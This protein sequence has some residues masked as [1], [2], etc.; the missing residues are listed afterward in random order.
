MQFNY[1]TIITSLVL[2]AVSTTAAFALDDHDTAAALKAAR[3]NENPVALKTLL[4]DA[5]QNS[6]EADLSSAFLLSRVTEVSTAADALQHWVDSNPDAPEDDRAFAYNQLGERYMGATRYAEAAAAFRMAQSFDLYANDQDLEDQIVLA[7]IAASVPPISREGAMGASIT[8]VNDLARLRRGPINISGVTSPMIIDTGAEISVAAQSV[9]EK[10]NMTFLDGDVTV[11]TATDNV[12]GRLAVSN[13]VN[14]GGMVFRNV[15]FLVLPDEQLTFADGQYFVDGIIGLP[16]FAEA[17][18][19]E[20]RD[21]AAELYLGN[22]VPETGPDSVPFYW[23]DSGMGL[24]IS[25]EQFTRPAFFDSGASRSSGEPLFRDLLTPADKASLIEENSTVTGVGG[26][27]EVKNYVLP[28]AKIMVG[29]KPFI[30]SNFKIAGEDRGNPT[31]DMA[32][33]GMDIVSLTSSFSVD[34]DA[35]TYQLAM[36]AGP[37]GE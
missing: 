28:E 19:M 29:G 7:E 34:F 20:W 2:T 18:R 30:R 16:L 10:S 13:D 1:K 5:Q 21:M 6:T 14:I 17:G 33:I 36:P 15:L 8:L 35:M 25:Y 3:M 12:S 31:G 11:G 22:T 32:M 4:S 26:T 24:Q 9:A 23:H 37:E 27:H